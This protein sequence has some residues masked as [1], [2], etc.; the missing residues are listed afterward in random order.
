MGWLFFS[1]WID[2]PMHSPRW[3]QVTDQDFSQSLSLG[4]M[5]TTEATVRGNAVFYPISPLTTGTSTALHWKQIKLWLIIEKICQSSYGDRI[6]Y[7]RTMLCGKGCVFTCIPWSVKALLAHCGPN[8]IC[9][10]KETRPDSNF[11]LPY[12]NITNT[13]QEWM[14]SIWSCILVAWTTQTYLF[15]FLLSFNWF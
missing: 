1:I 11:Y 5:V 2:L 3:W 8:S 10:L 6:Q 15:L 12:F 4:V 9:R 14:R 7:G 13:R